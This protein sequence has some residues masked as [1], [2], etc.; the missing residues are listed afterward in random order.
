MKGIVALLLLTVLATT[1]AIAFNKILDA[2]WFI[3]KV[4][5]RC[6][7]IDTVL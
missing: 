7:T 5:T 3:F 6:L 2:E 4:C 1:Q